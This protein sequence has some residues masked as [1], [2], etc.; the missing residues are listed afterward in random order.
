MFLVMA[1]LGVELLEG[2][3]VV[4][5]VAAKVQGWSHQVRKLANLVSAR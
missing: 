4:V 3:A 5:L 2:L 1:M